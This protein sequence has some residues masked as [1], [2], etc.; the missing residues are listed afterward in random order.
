MENRL[1]N[2]RYMVILAI[3]SALVLLFG[4]FP[5]GV[6]LGFIRTA[7]V[8][9]T[10]VHIPVILGAILLGPKAGGVLGFMF[11]LTS[12]LNATFF[13]PNPVTSPLFTPFFD[14]PLIPS[15]WWSLVICFLPRILIGVAAGLLFRVLRETVIP[16]SVSLVICGIVGSLVNTALVVTGLYMFFGQSLIQ[17]LDLT[18]VNF[19]GFVVAIVT[20]NGLIEI[21]AAGILA[22]LVGKALLLLKKRGIINLK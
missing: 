12:F 8:E 21:A 4:L 18:G 5:L 6:P 3:F 20:L 9:I 16:E 22:L 14:S 7:A 13:M 11:G 2:T 10:V 19:M 15:S 1:S 17:A